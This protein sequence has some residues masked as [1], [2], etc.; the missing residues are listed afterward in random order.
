MY[1]LAP[2]SEHYDDGF[3]AVGD[4]FFEAAKTLK[5]DNNGSIRSLGDLPEVY[6]LRHAVELFLKSGI[7]IIH[8]KLRLPYDSE[9]H[10]SAKPLMETS[11]GKWKPLLKTHDIPELY[12]YWKELIVG[13]KDKL[14]KLMKHTADV[15]V[16][17]ELDGWIKT[18]GAA[19]PDS[20]YFRYPVS[21]NSVADKAKSPFKEIPIP[22]LTPGARKANEQTKTFV[23]EARKDN[24]YL[25]ALFVENAQGELVKIF[26][27]DSATNKPVAEAAREAA[28]MLSNFH[29]MMRVELAGG[30]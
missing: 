29:F 30:W 23:A 7:I 6:L 12:R 4:A 17:A 28:D 9:P 18:L 11:S 20:D 14:V 26:A 10:T 1:M 2:L 15:D 24:E 3:G 8:R 27:H 21:K 19:D 25:K 16:P 22:S 5:K 13:N